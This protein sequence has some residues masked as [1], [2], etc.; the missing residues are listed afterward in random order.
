MLADM[1][2]AQFKSLVTS[3]SIPI[4]YT[5]RG[6]TYHLY[7][8]DGPMRLSC[9]IAVDGGADVVD[10]ESNYKELDTTNMSI[11]QYDTDGAQIVRTKAAKKGWTYSATSIEFTTSD[12]SSSVYCK[13]NEGND[14]AGISLKSYNGSNVEVTVPGLLN[15]NLGTI[16]KTVLDFEPP[17]DYE[18]IGG[19]IR[20][21]SSIASDMRL[22]IVAVPDIPSGSGG[23]KEMATC[24]NLKYLTP[25]NVYEVDGRVSKYLA[26]D[27]TYHT[28]KLRFILKYPAGTTETLAL[29]L[30]YYR[31]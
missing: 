20:T 18:I 23:S 2:W 28:N 14:V 26:Y 4:Q 9:K 31:P 29:T 25:G 5:T 7:A 19:N 3:K 15:V 8:F 12:L 10:F 17:F 22:W 1:D 30:E 27:A 16:T 6:T 11:W 24:V 21:V 13:D